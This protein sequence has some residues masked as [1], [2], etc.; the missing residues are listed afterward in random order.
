MKKRRGLTKKERREQKRIRLAN[1]KLIKKYSWLRPRS[2][3]TGKLLDDYNYGYT[4]YDCVGKG[5]QKA[6]GLMMLDEIDRELRIH[7]YR[8][9]YI[10][11]QVKEKFGTLRW[12]DNGGANETT[13][14]YENI[15][16]HVCYFCGRPDTH[17]T[18]MGWVL[19]VCPKCYEKR[20]RRGSKYEYDEVICDDNPRIEDIRRVNRYSNGKES[21]IEYNIKDTADIIR[22]W[23]NKNHSDDQVEV[24]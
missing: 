20:W 18:D 3:W 13:W 11:Y 17:V 23:W 2:V 5:W 19:P 16:E 6:F 7:N 15:S 12:Y 22:K 21:I 1:K 24:K 9:K 4:E 14:K 10:I 8:D